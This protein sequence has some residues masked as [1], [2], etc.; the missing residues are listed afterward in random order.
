[1]AEDIGVHLHLVAAGAARWTAAS[2]DLEAAWAQA[3]GAILALSTERTWGADG[4][5]SAFAGAYLRDGGPAE[6]L[7]GTGAT[8]GQNLV[9]A[10]GET[11]PALTE[12]V[13]QLVADDRDAATRIAASDGA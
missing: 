6:V 9:T 3:R 10:V 5:G 11:G 2:A 1:M 12:S 7:F 13:S 4:P 8:G